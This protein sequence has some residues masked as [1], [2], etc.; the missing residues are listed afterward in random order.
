LLSFPDLLRPGLEC[1]CAQWKASFKDLP[2]LFFSLVSQDSFPE[3]RIDYLLEELEVCFAKI[4]GPDF[5]FHLTLILQDC[6]L[7]Q[8]VITAQAV[9]LM[10]PIISLVLVTNRPS[11]ASPLVRLSRVTEGTTDAVSL[12]CLHEKKYNYN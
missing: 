9:I 6:K 7:Q 12:L 2:A 1:S 8:R 11:T 10:S 4:Q 3:G 5:S